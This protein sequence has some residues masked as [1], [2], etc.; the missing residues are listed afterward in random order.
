MAVGKCNSA[1]AMSCWFTSKRMLTLS[2]SNWRSRF[3][4]SSAVAGGSGAAVTTVSD[5][6]RFF[7]YR[8]DRVTGRL[9]A[10]AWIDVA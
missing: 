10:A 7:S 4:H 9:A 2:S 1:P 3:R 6:S 5:P 8:R